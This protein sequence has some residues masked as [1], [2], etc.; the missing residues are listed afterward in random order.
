MLSRHALMLISVKQIY[1]V[2]IVVLSE[3]MHNE[4]QYRPLF[5]KCT[6]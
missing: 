4:P 1:T 3:N 6:L 5:A 2:Y